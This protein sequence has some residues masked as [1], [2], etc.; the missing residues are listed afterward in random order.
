MKHCG[1][2]GVFLGI[3]SGSDLILGNMNKQARVEAYR[4]GIELLRKYDIMT[5]VSFIVGFPGETEETIRETIDFIDTARP[6]F[7][8]TQLWYYD[9]MTPIHRQ[10]QEFGLRNSQFEWTHRTMNARQAADWVDYFH[11][12]IEQSVWVPQTDFDVPGVFNLLSRGWS[13]ERV[14]DM[15]QAFNAKVRAKLSS[16]QDS[17]QPM[18]VDPRML[19]EAEFHFEGPA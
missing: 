3:E 15:I 11:R 4:R 8:R 1:C 10:A 16:S 19:R 5:Y 14:K 9:T 18:Y 12:N 6:D 17:Q 2:E 7:F 13:V